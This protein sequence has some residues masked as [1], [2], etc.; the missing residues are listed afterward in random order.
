MKS[1]LKNIKQ[2]QEQWKD[3]VLRFR[4]QRDDPRADIAQRKLWNRLF[5]HGM[6][7]KSFWELDF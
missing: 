6:F 7:Y 4:T 1:I 2:Q 3:V 5:R